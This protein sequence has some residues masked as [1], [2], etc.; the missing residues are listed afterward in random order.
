MRY[1]K[2]YRALIPSF[3]TKNQGVFLCPVVRDEGSGCK[4]NL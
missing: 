3:R 4:G 1:L 2:V